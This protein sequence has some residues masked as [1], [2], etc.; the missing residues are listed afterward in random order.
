MQSGGDSLKKSSE[1]RSPATLR[2]NRRIAPANS[3]PLR[4]ST[5]HDVVPRAYMRAPW[6]VSRRS[7]YA[8]RSFNFWT[9]REARAPLSPRGAQVHSR[10][11]ESRRAQRAQRNE[12]FGHSDNEAWS[13]TSVH[14]SPRRARPT[15]GF[16]KEGGGPLSNRMLRFS[17]ACVVGRSGDTM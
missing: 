8:T 9:R 17:R 2:K 6:I 16:F 5:T 12:R 15:Q 11:T 14:T 13:A 10:T 7:L 4:E 3:D 1:P